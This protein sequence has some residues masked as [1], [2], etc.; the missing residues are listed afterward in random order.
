MELKKEISEIGKL[1]L[2]V[3]SSQN[4]TVN[5]YLSYEKGAEYLAE[6]IYREVL[7]PLGW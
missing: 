4:P 1:L 5:K 6:D 7:A 3:I 2:D